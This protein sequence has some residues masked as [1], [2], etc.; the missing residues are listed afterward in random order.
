MRVIV[1]FD[2]PVQTGEQVGE[3]EY[4]LNGEALLTAPILA[5]ENVTAQEVEKGW[6]D[7]ILDWISSLLGRIQGK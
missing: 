7:G 3:V 5:R 1:F 6:L 2:L 4:S